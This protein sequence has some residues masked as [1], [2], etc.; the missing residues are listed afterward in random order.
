MSLTYRYSF[1]APA[2]TPPEELEG[3]LRSVET[4][5]KELGFTPTLVLNV[6]FNTPEQREFSRHLGGSCVLE[7]ERLKGSLN[8]RADEVRHHHSASGT[9]RLVPVQ[10]VVLVVTD[11]HARESCFGFMKYPGEIRDANGTKIM[12]TPF[13]QRWVFTDYVNS[14]DPRYRQIVQHFRTAGY[15]E[16]ESDDYARTVGSP[17]E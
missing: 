16:E 6:H 5:A 7:D 1:T 3:F 11:E 10:G 8:L 12:D 17:A 4:D 13:R 2:N 14:P 15:L 9:V